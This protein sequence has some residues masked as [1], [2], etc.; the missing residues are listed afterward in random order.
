MYCGKIFF[1][2]NLIL[3]IKYYNKLYYGIIKIKQ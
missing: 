3:N 1:I 2:F